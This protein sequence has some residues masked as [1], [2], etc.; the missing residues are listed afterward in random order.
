MLVLRVGGQTADVTVMSV[1]SGM[2]HVCASVCVP[3]LGGRIIDDVLVEHFAAE[4]QRLEPSIAV[5]TQAVET[6]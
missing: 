6:V 5:K 2:Y 4:F 1:N 3:D